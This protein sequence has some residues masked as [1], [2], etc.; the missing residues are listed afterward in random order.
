MSEACMD[1]FPA[2]VLMLMDLNPWIGFA[3]VLDFSSWIFSNDFLMICLSWTCRLVH[4]IY[5]LHWFARFINFHLLIVHMNNGF[6]T[7]RNSNS[8]CF[9]KKYLFLP[10][11]SMMLIMHVCSWN[12]WTDAGMQIRCKQNW[13]HH[14][15]EFEE[16]W[17]RVD[18]IS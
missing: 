2:H 3:S 14:C 15:L 6:G 16:A 17:F 4:G 8:W 13:L 12:R 11:F 10:S 1:G 5:F 7:D 18:V 9:C